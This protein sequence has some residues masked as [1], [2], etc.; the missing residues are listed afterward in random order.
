MRPDG[1]QF[2][3]DVPAAKGFWSNCRQSGNG[4]SSTPAVGRDLARLVRNESAPTDPRH[5]FGWPPPEGVKEMIYG[6]AAGP[7]LWIKSF[8]CE[9][10]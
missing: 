1:H 8:I 3:R 7:Q 2:I 6:D 5:L 4:F 9:S 10:C